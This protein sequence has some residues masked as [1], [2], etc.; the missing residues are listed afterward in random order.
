MQGF[1]IHQRWIGL[2]LVLL[3]TVS[4]ITTSVWADTKAE[5]LT[6][7]RYPILSLT[8]TAGERAVTWWVP[9]NARDVSLCYSTDRQMRE[10]E[11]VDAVKC[12]ELGQGEQVAVYEAVMSNLQADTT[13]YYQLCMKTDQGD[14]K[15]SP[16][17][18]YT[19]DE[20]K[21]NQS[22][23][24]LYLGDA[25]PDEDFSEY[26][27]WE[28]LVKRAVQQ[29]IDPAF[30]LLGGDMVNNGQDAEDWEA[31]LKRASTLFQSIP[32]MSAAGN[33]E[34]NDVD[35]YR[36][37]LYKQL[38]SLPKNGP[39]G[40]EEEFYSFDYGNCHIA[41]LS[42]NI[43]EPLE[44]GLISEAELEK[45][46][47]WIKEDL[48]NS[49]G[50]FNIVVTHHPAYSVV[51]DK[52]AEKV[53]ERWSPIFEQGSVDLVLCGHQHVYM[54][55][56]PMLQGQQNDED[57]VTYIMG[58]SGG[59]SYQESN[60]PYAA[61]LQ[62][63]V[64]NYQMISVNGE[65]MK[66]TTRDGENNILDQVT[67]TSKTARQKQEALEEEKKKQEALE[68]EKKKQIDAARKRLGRVTGV[69][70]ASASYHKIR[71]TW[72][73]RSGADGYE[74]Y[75][76]KGKKGAYKKVADRKKGSGQSYV[77]AGRRT[78]TL[79]RYKIR[80][81]QLVEGTK[82]Y[83]GFSAARSAKPTLKKPSVKIKAGKG[84]ITL[85]WKP[86]SGASGYQIYRSGKKNKGYKRIKTVTR[87]KTAK[88][89]NKKLKKGKRYYFKVRAYR[90][91]GGKKV[92]SSFSAVKY[93]KVK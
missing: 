3:M 10:K 77:L 24:F 5:T 76:A 19:G 68:A 7:A 26:D 31:Y 8:G 28:A 63:G 59:K 78:G 73:A 12:R 71:L 50:E 65:Q 66:I 87:G 54:R 43:F 91:V 2:L 18:F 14:Y 11:T 75:E 80:A 45:I 44:N 89:R 33:H 16:V 1:R 15:S 67:L 82:V 70:A 13:Y 9:Q 84:K 42:S 60:V 47:T 27:Q 30:A 81:Y 52:T 6:E 34:C 85:K 35:T 88:Y 83:S 51:S 72:S 92:Y 21:E 23:S 55:T 62:G 53:L 49:Q 22:F 4:T 41:V 36:P 86:V 29:G 90:R 74:I 69:K 46:E 58:V 64:S 17:G 57:G 48:K 40:F 38:F 61:V 93:K 37:T 32:A 20:G 79:Y 56:K 39:Q 25:Q